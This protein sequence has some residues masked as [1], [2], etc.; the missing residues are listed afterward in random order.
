MSHSATPSLA[1]A[2]SP[3]DISRR[4]LGWQAAAVLVGTGVLAL[5]SHIQVPMFP[6]PMTMQTLAVT[7]IGA[8][9][10]WRLGAITVLAWLAEAWMGL[11]VTATGSIG[12]LL[13][14][15][16]TAGYLISFPLVSVLCGW[17]AERG[18]NGN[19]PVLAFTSMVAGNALCLAIGGAWLATMIGVEKAFLAGVAP[20]VLGGLLKSL[21]GAVTLTALARGKAGAAQ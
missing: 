15:G 16:P 20:F 10:G 6:V 4:S 12:T 3:L 11:P 2:Y 5:A 18:W 17:L 14:V 7:L 1:P 13:F 19:R 9:Y 21:I 8:L